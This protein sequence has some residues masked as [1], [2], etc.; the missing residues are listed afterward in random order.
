MSGCSNSLLKKTFVISNWYQM[1][2]S[3]HCFTVWHK[4][5]SVYV[6]NI[7]C[8]SK[9]LLKNGL[10]TLSTGLVELNR[11]RNIKLDLWLA[12]NV[13]WLSRTFLAL[14][15][16]ILRPILMQTC[17]N[18]F[19]NNFFLRQCSYTEARL[20]YLFLIRNSKRNNFRIR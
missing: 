4:F 5:N 11:L 14:S 3:K 13:T 8:C 12:S 16:N 15:W 10:F 9:H 7:S 1:Q 2:L 18:I 19:P 20:N 6:L 17:C